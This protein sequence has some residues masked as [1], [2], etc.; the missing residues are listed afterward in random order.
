MRG[1][2]RQREAEKKK[3]RKKAKRKII[4]IVAVVL[5]VIVAA[6]FTYKIMMRG[7]FY[8][9]TVLN[10]YD[11]SG[12]SVDEVMEL[13]KESY[14]ELSLCITEGGEEELKATFQEIGYTMKEE[15]LRRDI[16]T[17]MGRQGPEVFLSMLLGSEYGMRVPFV[18]DETVFKEA[19]SGSHFTTPRVATANAQ[20][21]QS[22]GEYIVEPE[23]Y[24]NDFDDSELQSY[25]KEAIG[26]GLMNSSVESVITVEMP[27]SIYRIPE[28]TQQNETLNETKN[29][30]NKYC[31][32][33]ITHTFG[34]EK[35]VLGWDTI[36]EWITDDG[37]IDEESVYNYAE[38]L[39]MNYDTIYVD[40]VFE[41]SNG[42][43]ITLPSND[44]G[45]QI[46]VDGEFYQLLSDIYDN[47]ATEREPV[48][49]IRGFSRNGY[50]DL[51][52][53]YVEV[54]LTSQQL[55][56][57]RDGELIVQSGIISGLPKD[58]RETAQG[59]FAIPYKQS[60]ANLVGQGGGEGES[61]D[62]EVKYWM[63]FHDGQG[64]HDASWQSNF[65]GT[66]Y[67]T[68][69][70]HGCVNLPEDVAAIIY[71]YME[72]NMPIILYK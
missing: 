31:K 32:A 18:V 70:S 9:N 63:P 44:Y 28:I 62:V 23:V 40:R 26:K 64:L 34:E 6:E 46:D 19:V 22:N 55:W 1:S 13:L 12:K 35:L 66:T 42:E 21:V 51:N 45:Y 39:A 56:F 20:L 71:E 5:A 16:E 52:G 27:K 50:D 72:E 38:N 69:G 30:Y 67:L 61:W 47:T 54:D 8:G 11:V 25:V 2:R 58:D 17:L 37:E 65:G 53:N 48:Y 14:G 36:Q 15:Q 57:Y 68:A 43:T 41:T 60:P 4:F 10:G 24:G 7:H 59:A 3:A 49:A 33:E 29:L